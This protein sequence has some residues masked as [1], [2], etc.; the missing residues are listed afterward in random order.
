MSYTTEKKSILRRGARWK[1]RCTDNNLKNWK[2][3]KRRKWDKWAQQKRR[4]LG[5]RVALCTAC[6][7]IYF[8]PSEFAGE[9]DEE[10]GSAFVF[11]FP[12]WIYMYSGD[13]NRGRDCLC[14]TTF[15]KF[16]C[17]NGTE[18]R[19][20]HLCVPMIRGE[21]VVQNMAP[22]GRVLCDKLS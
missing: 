18:V 3:E 11:T 13:N 17:I 1:M 22:R 20:R 14:L 6:Q 2:G 19:P 8:H 10:E 7:S 5:T 15:F 21:V 4:I 9:T 12:L 16:H